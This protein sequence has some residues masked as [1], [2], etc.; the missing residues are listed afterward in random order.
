MFWLCVRFLIWTYVAVLY[1]WWWI[2]YNL[3][4]C[5]IITTG[6]LAARVAVSNLHKNTEKSFSKTIEALYSFIEV[7]HGLL[8]IGSIANSLFKYVSCFCFFRSRKLEWRH[9]WSRR[10]SIKSLWPTRRCL[11]QP[12]FMIGTSSTITSGSRLL[13]DPTCMSM[14]VIL[15][16]SHLYGVLIALDFLAICLI[17]F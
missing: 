13:N 16:Q 17:L 12:L 8:F 2:Y 4:I 3:F 14:K 10:M 15:T 6:L 1:V 9:R 5:L 11:I 7:N